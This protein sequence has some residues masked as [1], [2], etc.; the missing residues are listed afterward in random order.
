MRVKVREDSHPGCHGQWASSL[1]IAQ[2]RNRTAAK[3][4]AGRAFSITDKMPVFHPRR[5]H[6][7]GFSR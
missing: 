1:L 5:N 7:G 3:K 2:F 6:D 4:Q